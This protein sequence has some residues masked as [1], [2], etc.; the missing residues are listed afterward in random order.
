MG[1]AAHSV[2]AK[3]VVHT[4]SAFWFLGR[5]F[6]YR[7]CSA[8]RPQK[9]RSTT[10]G[11]RAQTNS[12]HALAP[13]ATATP[14]HPKR[15]M[16]GRH[17]PRRRRT[18]HPSYVIAAS[19]LR[20]A[21]GDQHQTPWRAS[22]SWPPPL[23]PLRVWTPPPLPPRQSALQSADRGGPAFA[24][25]KSL[26]PSAAAGGTTAPRPAAASRFSMRYR[27]AISSAPR[28]ATLAMGFEIGPHLPE[29]PKAQRPA[30]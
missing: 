25:S 16:P 9:L 19:C 12:A 18:Q 24:P 8:A 15:R 30:A 10:C 23:C 22:C 26:L 7:P 1:R 27:S 6:R 20:R 21:L 28:F 5:G 4:S 14:Q 29:L 17:D 11:L 3:A 2:E 13:G